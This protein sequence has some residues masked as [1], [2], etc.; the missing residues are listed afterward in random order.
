MGHISRG[1]R[2]N[3][4]LSRASLVTSIGDWITYFVSI[5]YLHKITNSAL[6]AAYSVPMR[7]LGMA[8]GAGI[9][10]QAIERVGT[11]RVMLIAQGNAAA[12]VSVGLTVGILLFDRV[13][14]S[15]VLFSAF[16]SAVGKYLFD[17]ARETH[18]KGLAQAGSEHRTLQSQ[19][20]GGLA[21]AQ[22]IGPLLA[23]AAVQFVPVWSLYIVTG[24]K[25]A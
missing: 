9:G 24:G 11:R 19:I 23:L 7:S 20:L 21:G 8:F 18:S 14:P 16:L 25:L 22:F 12:A 5:F 13:S 3:K 1:Q 4:L 2:D 15:L 10:A 17:V 6:I